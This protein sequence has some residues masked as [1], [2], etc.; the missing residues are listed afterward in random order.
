MLK[1]INLYCTP[2]TGMRIRWNFETLYSR[3]RDPLAQPFKQNK[4]KGTQRQ[5]KTRA[6]YQN[7]WL[8]C[9]VHPCRGGSYLGKEMRAC[10]CENS[11]Y[12][13]IILEKN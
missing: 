10:T 11:D 5:K 9:G 3:L 12:A 4:K 1:R 2:L 7:K 8:V 13:V 6:V